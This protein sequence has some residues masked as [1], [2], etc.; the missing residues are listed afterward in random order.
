MK[1][2]SA[3]EVVSTVPKKII[4]ASLPFI[5]NACNRNLQT[6][7][8]QLVSEF[9]PHINLRLSFRNHST[10]APMLKFKDQVPMCVRSNIVYQYKCGICNSKYIGETSR[11][12]NTRVAEHMGVSPRTGAPMAK[13]NSNVY[14]HFLESGHQVKRDDFSILYSRDSYEIKIS[15][16]ISLHQFKPNLNDK[17]YSVPLEILCE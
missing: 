7:I 10:T 3:H 16:S 15:E 8:S 2:K 4:Y 14:N 1:I 6:T 13:V 11:H 5:S 12:F 9:L 17:I